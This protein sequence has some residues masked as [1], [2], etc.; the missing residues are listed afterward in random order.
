[1]KK[2]VFA[3]VA[4]LA[5]TLG[6]GCA[7]VTPVGGLLTDIKLPVTATPSSTATKTGVAKCSSILGL[8]AQGDCSLQAAKKAGG[9]STV[10]HVEWKANNILGIIGNYELI[11]HGQ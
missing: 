1:M 2:K 10:S 11:V 7:T 3:A 9:I 8:I 6:T 5:A 4:V